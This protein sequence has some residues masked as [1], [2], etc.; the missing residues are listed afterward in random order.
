MILLLYKEEFYEDVLNSL[1]ESGINDS[2]VIEGQ[3]INQAVNINVPIFSGL[4]YKLN[5]ESKYSKII[6][7][8]VDSKEQVE[9]LIEILKDLKID[10]EREDILRIYIMKI[11]SVYGKSEDFKIE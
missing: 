1:V 6:L 9:H 11:D 4:K 10:P 5:D 7:S 8:T 2:F 3:T